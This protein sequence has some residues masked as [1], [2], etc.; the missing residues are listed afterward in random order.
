[1]STNVAKKEIK[2]S[3]DWIAILMN[4]NL[5]FFT[6]FL[7]VAKREGDGGGGGG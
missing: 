4:L 3:N 5:K 1:M 6:C 2:F 7:R